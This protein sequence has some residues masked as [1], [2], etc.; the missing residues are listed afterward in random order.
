MGRH[1]KGTLAETWGR[2]ATG[3]RRFRHDGCATEDFSSP[4][5]NASVA[6]WRIAVGGLMRHL[7][8][9][10]CVSIV[11]TL[12]VVAPA[13]AGRTWCS[14]DPIVNVDGHTIQVLVAI[15]DEYVDLV[16]GPI[17]VVFETP[18]G[19]NRS[20]VF[21]DDG[22]N[23]FGETVS[24]VDAPRRPVNS[25]SDFTLSVR[26]TVPIDESLATSTLK[27]TQIPTW[28]TVT[29]GNTSVVLHGWSSGS[30][31]TA[32]IGNGR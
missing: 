11:A 3:L 24:F 22:F 1:D 16:N 29:E 14:R 2:K 20:V 10:V 5:F 6:V 17:D 21:T 27:T 4:G 13:S 31:V 8:F 15:P 30:W 26:V 32:R 28:I 23:G 7:V 18:A 9:S 19:M 12:M 25:Q